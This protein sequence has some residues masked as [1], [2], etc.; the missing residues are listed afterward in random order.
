MYKMSE[1]TVDFLVI[2]GGI[3]GLRAAIE[4]APHGS[5]LVLTKD[6]PTESSTEYAQGGIAVALSDEDEVGIHYEDTLRAGDGLCRKEAVRV[7]VEEGPTLIRQLISW[8]ALFDKTEDAFIFTHEAAHS[9]KRILRAMGDSTGKEIERTLIEKAK[10]MPRIT[11]YDFSFTVDL[12][13]DENRCFGSMVLRKDRIMKI[14]A[15]AVILATGG[16]G[17][18]YSRTTN[19]LIATG[20]GMAIAYRADAFL[21]DT[22]FI[23]FHPTSLYCP[24]AP[25]FLLSEAMRGEGGVLRNN[26]GELFMDNYHKDAELAPRD[27]VSR[28]IVSELVKTG[29]KHVY[30]DMTHLDRDFVRSRFPRIWRTCLQ[31]DLDIAEDWIPVSPSAHYV[32]GGVKTDINGVTSIEG[33]FAAGEVACTGVHGANRLASNSLLEGLVFGARS[34][35]ACVEYVK[36]AKPVTLYPNPPVFKDRHELRNIEKIRQ[37]L[38]RVMWNRVGIIRCGESLQEAKKFFH[39]WQH[40]LD[41]VV[42]NRPYLEL[43]NMITVGML[44]MEAAL[45]RKESVGA[46]YRSDFP[47]KGEPISII[48][49]RSKDWDKHNYWPENIIQERTKSFT[50]ASMSSGVLD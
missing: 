11:R 36:R 43:K 5:V 39:Q 32:M 18:I 47:S 20:D 15:K 7:M 22:E 27:I 34:G 38:K 9:K 29:A 13:V 40:L 19:P 46:H 21:E 50:G 14:F 6:T 42:L 25:Q 48:Q 45:F 2:G 33:L 31:Y 49:R 37:T 35:R 16:A 17:Q 24:S 41:N 10:T 44:V 4:L 30:L 3:A 12:I 8:G 23:Q 26:C 1:L 28:A